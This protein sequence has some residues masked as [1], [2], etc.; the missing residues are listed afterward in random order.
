MPARSRSSDE[1]LSQTAVLVGAVLPGLP[2]FARNDAWMAKAHD[3]VRTP[4]QAISNRSVMARRHDHLRHGEERSDVTS[5]SQTAD[6]R[7]AALR[8]Q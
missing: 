5:L 8:S 4:G 6:L 7:I 3:G 2:R 1:S